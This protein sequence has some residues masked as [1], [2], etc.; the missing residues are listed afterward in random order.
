VSTL[1]VHV[2]AADEV[3]R[4][5]VL[6][7]LRRAGVELAA[8]P[9]G[10][11]DTVTAVAADTLDEAMLACPPRLRSDGHPLLFVADRF[12]PADV[13]HALRA[14]VRTM[15][16]AADATPSRLIAA[17]H[18]ARDGDGQL[19]HEALLGAL[20]GGAPTPVATAATV[21]APSL[22]ARQMRV[23]ELMAE[24]QDNATIAR[25]LRCSEHTV[26]NV[27]YDLMVRLGVRNRAHAVACGVRAGLI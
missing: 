21:P 13:V 14:G 22:T 3:R 7:A 9:L 4:S 18:S 5:A 15:I 2:I 6:T 1:R 17:L 8:E 20:S 10:S 16:R 27:I 25:T 26:K 11:S 24:G 23:L 12:V 19:P